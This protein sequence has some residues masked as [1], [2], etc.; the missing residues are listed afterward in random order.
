MASRHTADLM[1]MLEKML[2]AGFTDPAKHIAA[3]LLALQQCSKRLGEKPLKL[4]G[5]EG[6][7]PHF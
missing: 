5:G 7:P 2:D 6:P 1:A 4:Q 3:W